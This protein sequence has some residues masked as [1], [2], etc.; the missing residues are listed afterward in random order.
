M[1]I[2]SKIKGL[3]PAKPIT[4]PNASYLNSKVYEEHMRK[5]LPFGNVYDLHEAQNKTENYQHRHHA[6]NHELGIFRW[7]GIQKH[8]D[9]ILQYANNKDLKIVDLGGAACPLGF[10]SVIVDFL[11]KDASGK[12]VKYKYLADLPFKADLIFTSHTLEHVEPLE[13]VVGQMAD[14]LVDGGHM[15][16]HVPSFYCERWR[17]EIH[18][19]RKYNDHAWTFGLAGSE[20]PD[21]LK[22]YKHIDSILEKKFDLLISE[23]CGDDS[24]FIYGRKKS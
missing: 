5:H 17:S 7:R 21:G 6:V 19:N 22:N 9:L 18:S 4:P 13:E 15:M 8:K 23:Y 10:D 24:I 11:K 14:T 16:A 2:I 20:I 3:K 1:G 12:E